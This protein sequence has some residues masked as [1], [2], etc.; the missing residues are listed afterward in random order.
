MVSEMLSE[1][2]IEE[3]FEDLRYLFDAL[4]VHD[5]G[6][7][8]PDREDDSDSSP[9]VR[10]RGPVRNGTAPR[11]CPYRHGSSD[12]RRSPSPDYGLPSSVDSAVS[13]SPP[14]S[15]E[16]AHSSSSSGVG[17]DSE[18]E[19]DER[20]QEMCDYLLTLNDP[21]TLVDTIV[22]FPAGNSTV[23]APPS[24]EQLPLAVE[25]L[26]RQAPAVPRFRPIL[27]REKE[28]PC[29]DREEPVSPPA[30]SAKGPQW[31]RLHAA[32]PLSELNQAAGCVAKLAVSN[33]LKRRDKC[34]RTYLH[35]AVS[36]EKPALVYKLVERFHRQNSCDLLDAPDEH[37]Q[38]ALHYACELQQH[39]V[40]GVLCAAGAKR[41][42]CDADGITP[43]HVA[44]DRGFHCCIEEL[45]A[46]PCPGSVNVQDLRGRTPLHCAVLSH[47]GRLCVKNGGKEVY[48]R[49][50]C[51]TVVKLLTTAASAQLELQDRVG[52]TALHYAAQL[53]KAD[54]VQLLLLNADNPRALTAIANNA[55]DTALHMA[56]KSLSQEQDKLVRL[57][58]H[59][60]AS[61]DVLNKRGQRPVDL[62]PPHL[63]L[64]VG[65][66]ADI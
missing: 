3:P 31:A 45:L 40:V 27:P 9:E 17:L 42:M 30:K 2:P 35:E 34:G 32:L 28:S 33:S 55:G 58:V 19:N 10:R 38:T 66:L 57:L 53:H 20:F 12:G 22:D 13:L 47:G 4:C 52:E 11:P 62:L 25:E 37:G 26:N 5:E 8:S 51:R 43:M 44:A 50:D 39:L 16:T 36:H 59:Q 61:L 41:D 60:G 49:I 18:I 21:D 24:L 46:A 7:E 23:P 14:A 64:E 1:E 56:C 48:K 15:N 6:Y 54:L 63:R 29:R 65:L